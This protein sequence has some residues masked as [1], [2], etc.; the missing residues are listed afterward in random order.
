M[1]RQSRMKQKDGV[2]DKKRKESE[3]RLKTEREIETLAHQTRDDRCRSSGRRSHGDD[4]MG[5]K[6]RSRSECRPKHLAQRTLKEAKEKL[7]RQGTFHLPTLPNDGLDDD[8]HD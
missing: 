6:A 5:V 2:K 3:D 4:Q 7:R 1:E 8:D